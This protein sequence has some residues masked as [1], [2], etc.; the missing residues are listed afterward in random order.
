MPKILFDWFVTSV[1][2]D[3]DHTGAEQKWVCLSAW[4]GTVASDISFFSVLET[5][6]DVNTCVGVACQDF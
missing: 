6:E 3:L 2:I 4:Q 5:A 1:V